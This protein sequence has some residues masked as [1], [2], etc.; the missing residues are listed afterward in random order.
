MN[1]NNKSNISKDDLLN[2]REIIEKEMHQEVTDPLFLTDIIS[3]DENKTDK[4]KLLQS[5]NLNLLI[6]NVIKDIISQE[7]KISIN[8]AASVAIVD[9]GAFLI[10]RSP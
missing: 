6:K 1:E 2:V 10:K 7:L 4:N 8:A 9:E 5:S 3:I